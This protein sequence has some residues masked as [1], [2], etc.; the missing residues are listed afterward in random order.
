VAFIFAFK[1]CDHDAETYIV[2]QRPPM[3]RIGGRTSQDIGKK[4]RIPSGGAFSEKAYLPVEAEKIR[5]Q[6]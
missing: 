2:R 4:S 5:S 3:S 6:P 1:R